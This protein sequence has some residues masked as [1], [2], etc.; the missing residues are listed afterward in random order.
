MQFQNEYEKEKNILFNISLRFRR[1]KDKT[2]FAKRCSG[3]T[4]PLGVADFCATKVLTRI[5]YFF[6][7]LP[8]LL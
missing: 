5:K 8:K 4:N 1:L 6:L 7:N 2:P 3:K